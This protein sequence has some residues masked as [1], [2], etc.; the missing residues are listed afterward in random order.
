MTDVDVPSDISG[1]NEPTTGVH[2][3]GGGSKAY[4]VFPRT[5]L[6][7]T[8]RF[9]ITAGSRIF[10]TFVFD[11]RCPRHLAV[12]H[13]FSEVFLTLTALQGAEALRRSSSAEGRTPLA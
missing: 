4:V 2:S 6:Q 1:V 10:L 8:A 3:F 11:V 9:Q 13:G 7:M 5:P 12:N